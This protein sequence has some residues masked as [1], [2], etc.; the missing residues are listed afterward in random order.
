MLFTFT[1]FGNEAEL[2]GNARPKAR[3]TRQQLWT[4]QAKKYTMWKAH[5][6]AAFL[7]SLNEDQ[8]RFFY[9]VYAA[10]GKPIPSQSEKMRM[11]IS[12]YWKNDRHGDPENIFGSIADAMFLQDKFLAGSF[13]FSAS[14]EGAGRVEVAITI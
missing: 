13:D 12:I 6:V 11:D 5:V 10:N 2:L 1:I 9:N 7:K 4:P 3:L 14:D 8:R